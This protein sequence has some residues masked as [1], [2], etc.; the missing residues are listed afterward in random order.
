MVTE[1][2]DVAA[3]LFNLGCDAFQVFFGSD[4]G[5]KRDN[6]AFHMLDMSD[7]SLQLWKYGLVHLDCHLKFL[8]PATNN[9]DSSTILCQ[10]GRE[11]Y[12]AISY[13]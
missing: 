9:V 3:F 1:E 6:L 10:R 13:A 5:N 11:V 2:I 8:Q 12:R 4:I 7:R